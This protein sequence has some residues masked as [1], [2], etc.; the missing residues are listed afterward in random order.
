MND[1]HVPNQAVT[2]E[3]VSNV[4][5]TRR[6]FLS[7]GA[8]LASW[9]LVHAWPQEA[10]PKTW[11][12]CVIGHTGRGNY[13]HGLAV[14]FQKLP[15][16]TVVGLADPVE[17]GRLAAAKEARAERT[18]ADWAEM[19]QKEKPD[20]VANGPRWVEQRVEVFSLCAE[21]GASV[22]SEKPMALS[23]QD[24]D[25]ILDACARV[26]TAF[27]HQC[28]PMPQVV[29]ARKLLGEGIIGDLVEIRARG[30]EDRRSGGEDLMVLGT[31][32]MYLMR[33]FG[34][35]ALSCTAKITVDGRDVVQADRRAATEPLGPVAG[36]TILA[37]YELAKGVKGTFAS[38]KARRPG[39]QYG[40]TLV[41]TNGEILLGPG[42][43][44]RVSWRRKADDAPQPLPDAPSND[45]PELKGQAYANQLLVKDLMDC[46][47]TDRDPIASGRECRAALEMILA[48]YASHL[49]GSKVTLPLQ[50]R[51][52]PLG[53]L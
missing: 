41:G 53:T 11:R 19:L 16:I 48:T 18:Y 39:G 4:T 34:G 27:A 10:K 25:R 36:D 23:L 33:Y 47:G 37:T 15:N 35:V 31:H 5:S 51:T 21:L 43:P 38:E 12:A 44:S 49:S 50:D 1:G 2:F 14:A 45:G 26:K 3:A 20:L 32:C 22:Y 28:R 8:A 40:L 7:A 24:A 52:H 29:H 46:V 6:R 30:K 9:P 13:G 42:D 17:K